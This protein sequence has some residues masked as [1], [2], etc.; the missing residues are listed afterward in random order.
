MSRANDL[1]RFM[2]ERH[3]IYLRRA[4]GEL[5]PWTTDAILRRYRFC[6]VYR[7]LD[8]VTRWIRIN[9]RE[10]YCDHKNLWFMLCIARQINWPPTLQALMDGGAWPTG[11]R[12]NCMQARGILLDRHRRG[13]KIYTSAYMLTARPRLGE[14]RDKAY[15]TCVHA[16]GSVWAARAEFPRTIRENTLQT[17]ARWFYPFPGWG[18]FL[19]YEVVT[20][21]R[22]TDYL[23]NATDIDTWASAGPGA[24]RGLNRVHNRALTYRL[25]ATMA[26]EEIQKLLYLSRK[27]WI[28]DKL[29]MRD[30]EHSLCEFDK[31]ERVRTGTGKPK[32]TYEGE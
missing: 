25:S 22:H 18:A 10:P 3:S 4:A 17:A 7:E 13:E 15:Y 27:M 23:Y 21:L 31:Y 28:Y 30:I 29:E 1:F 11:N 5:R 6:N 8:T 16:L 12:W 32:S 9:I 14:P 19:A 26:N 24:L 2:S 20:D